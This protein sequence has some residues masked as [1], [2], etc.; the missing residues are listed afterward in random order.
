MLPL[1]LNILLQLK[2]VELF[3]KIPVNEKNGINKIPYKKIKLNTKNHH[4]NLMGKVECHKFIFYYIPIKYIEIYEQQNIGIS[5]CSHITICPF[6]FGIQLD[7]E[8]QYNYY[9][10]MM[11]LDMNITD[12]TYKL[13]KE[14]FCFEL[15]KKNIDSYEANLITEEETIVLNT[16]EL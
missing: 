13:L 9:T 4:N 14:N 1:N 7:I 10:K 15:I 8:E 11:N 5:I 3:G 16:Q 12:D 6:C 2:I